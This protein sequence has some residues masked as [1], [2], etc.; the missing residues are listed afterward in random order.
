MTLI[1]CRKAAGFFLKPGLIYN[2]KNPRALKNEKNLL[3]VHWM[4]HPKPWI[5]KMMTSEWFHQYFISQIKVYLAKKGLPFKV[6]F[7]DNAGC[8]AIDLFEGSDRIPAP[9]YD[10]HYP[11]HES[12][13]IGAFKPLYT[14][15]ALANLVA[16]MNAHED[17]DLDLR[18][19]WR[20]CTLA[21]CLENIHKALQDMKPAIIKAS[22][23]VVA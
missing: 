21:A 19:Y 6:L 5:T 18:S 22:W 16:L 17:K 1:M 20:E 4:H 2:S 14:R 7:M 23:K 15:N 13:V 11:T 8:H 10:V 9:E 3:P 12:G